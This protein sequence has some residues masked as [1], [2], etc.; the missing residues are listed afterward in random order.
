MRTL[1][2]AVGILV[3][4]SATASFAADVTYNKVVSKSCGTEAL[5]PLRDEGWRI[6]G[7]YLLQVQISSEDAETICRKAL[8]FAMLQMNSQQTTVNG[9]VTSEQRSGVL[10][11]GGIKTVCYRKSDK[12]ELSDTTD[13]TSQLPS[14]EYELKATPVSAVLT[15]TP[16]SAGTGMP[17]CASGPL[18]I[19]LQ[20]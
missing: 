13:T 15:L 14:L 19:G 3:L 12:A 18:Q 8:V 17:E 10:L 2:A 11:P 9:A 5:E 6:S 16:E 20:K 4:T 7:D 1:K